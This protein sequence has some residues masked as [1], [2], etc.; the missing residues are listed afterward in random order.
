MPQTSSYCSTYFEFV[1]IYKTPQSSQEKQISRLQI[2]NGR[3]ASFC[4][5]KTTI[6]CSLR[7]AI[8]FYFL[9]LCFTSFHSTS[10]PL[11]RLLCSNVKPLWRPLLRR[12]LEVKPSTRLSRRCR[13]I[14]SSSHH[15]QTLARRLSPIS[16][17]IFSAGAYYYHLYYYY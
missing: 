1:K 13:A 9:R 5:N 16:L 14:S 8:I 6:I 17:Q 11:N 2:E 4:Y 15:Q 3:F 7:I 12:V 10:C